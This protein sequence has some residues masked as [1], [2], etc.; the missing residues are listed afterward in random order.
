M[1]TTIEAIR[2]GEDEIH[3]IRGED[4]ERWVALRRACD[5][6]GIDAEGQRQK[7][8]RL[9]WAR[10]LTVKARDASGREQELFCLH[11]DSVPMWLA[12]LVP[13]LLAPEVQDKVR[14]WQ[15]GAAKA[16]ADW[17]YGRTI[18]A[19]ETREQLVARALIAATEALAEK[20]LQIAA[21]QPKAEVYDALVEASGLLCLQAAAKQLDEPP[22]L[23][24][25]W[26]RQQGHVYDR[27]GQTYARQDHLDA[28][29]MI[30]RTVIV[31]GKQYVQTK[32]T[33]RGLV[34]FAERRPGL[35]GV[36]R[37]VKPLTVALPGRCGEDAA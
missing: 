17:A 28:G 8:L 7:V 37:S 32:V 14:Y 5:A 20:D 15:K 16:L 13:S 19:P 3:G 29:R 1:S 23:W 35:R 25:R 4:G 34:Y 27:G 10:T 21:L 26:L 36:R 12:T 11:A 18:A 33:P 22:N 2:I 9:D 24:I 6:L 30:Q 31:D